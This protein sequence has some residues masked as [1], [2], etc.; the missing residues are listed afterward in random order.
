MNS[1]MGKFTNGGELK[2]R[3]IVSPNRH[4]AQAVNNQSL[5]LPQIVCNSHI[6][7]WMNSEKIDSTKA[8]EGGV[9][10]LHPMGSKRQAVLTRGMPTSFSMHT[11][12][13]SRLRRRG[14]GT[15]RVSWA[16]IRQCNVLLE[17]PLGHSM[18]L[19]TCST[20]TLKRLQ[21]HPTS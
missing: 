1:K 5:V 15:R 17:L 18:L 21:A 11:P 14:P 8:M 3:Q 12:L 4:W 16:R 19:G 2:T 6:M 10:V 13:T 20:S 9:K 7:Q